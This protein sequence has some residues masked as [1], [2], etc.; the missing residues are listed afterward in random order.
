MD[1]DT[2]VRLDSLKRG[3]FFRRKANASKTYTRGEYQRD[4]KRYQCDDESDISRSIDLPGKTL[5]YVG[6]DY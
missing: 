2:S 5:V 6:F 3:E 1:I 4:V